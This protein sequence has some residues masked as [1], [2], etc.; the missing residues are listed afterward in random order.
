V[1][2]GREAFTLNVSSIRRRAF[3]GERMDEPFPGAISDNRLGVQKK[4][5]MEEFSGGQKIFPVSS[6][7]KYPMSC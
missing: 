3:S 5:S 7:C 1:N 4:L 2:R 6:E